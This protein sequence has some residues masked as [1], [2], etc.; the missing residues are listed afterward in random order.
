M[1][2]GSRIVLATSLVAQELSSM[3]LIARGKKRATVT[4][5]RVPTDSALTVTE[6]SAELLM[7]IHDQASG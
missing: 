6:G 5:R 4:D 7:R 1:D 3:A 2:A